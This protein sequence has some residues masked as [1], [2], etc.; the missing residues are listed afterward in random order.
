M[1][2]PATVQGQRRSSGEVM[3][4]A[5]G[6]KEGAGAS[7]SS[8]LGSQNQGESRRPDP[9][10]QGGRRRGKRSA[11]R[12]WLGLDAGLEGG[13]EALGGRLRSRAPLARQGKV[14]AVYVSARVCP[15]AE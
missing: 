15:R 5:I 4:A 1:T 10:S 7:S 3:A 6:G 12:R 11:A 13:A 9:V 2:E 8:W 14:V